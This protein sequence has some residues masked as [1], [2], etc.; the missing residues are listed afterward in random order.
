MSSVYSILYYNLEIW[1]L[2]TLKTELKSKLISISARAIKLCMY[3]PDKT[4]SFENIHKMNNRAMPTA[5]MLY[6]S[7]IQ[8]FK[9]YNT[10]EHSWEWIEMNFKQIITSRQ[11]AFA[12]L[13]TN[14]TKVGINQLSNRFHILNG[15]IPLSWLNGSLD[16]L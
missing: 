3:Y 9:L 7:A 14:V 1:H 4:I 2:P 13:K 12:T 11:T 8:L 5:I 6:K 16:S 10:K 15:Q